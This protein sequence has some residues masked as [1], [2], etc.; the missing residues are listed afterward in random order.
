MLFEKVTMLSIAILVMLENFK[1][2]RHRGEELGALFIDFSKV[3][4]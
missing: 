2:S 3:F 1:K 4:H